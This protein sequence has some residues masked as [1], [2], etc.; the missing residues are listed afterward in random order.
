[1][2]AGLAPKTILVDFEDAVMK[3]VEEE[4]PMVKIQGCNFHFC[5]CIMRHISSAGLKTQYED[6]IDF[7][8][9]MRHLAALA[10]VPPEKVV[11]AFEELQDTHI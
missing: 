2:K 11:H 7:A 1:M 9:R 6:D 4:F 10:Y 3:V 5:Q 8:F